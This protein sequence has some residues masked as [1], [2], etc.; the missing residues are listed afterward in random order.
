MSTLPYAYR[1]ATVV[2]ILEKVKE[3]QTPDRFTADFLDTKLGFKGGTSKQFIPFAKKLCLLS[4]DGSPTELYRKFRN[5]AT[6][7][8][9]IAE[10]LRRGYHEIFERNEYA[11]GLDREKFKGLVVEITGLEARN[12][13][14]QMICQTFELLRGMADFEAKEPV[15]EEENVNPLPPEGDHGVREDFGLNLSYTINLVLPKTDDP[16]VLNAI[17]RALRENLLKR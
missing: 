8:L 6:S 16:S 4:G 9:A 15:K 12:R 3:A 14:V 2:R 7:K 17:F 11:Y 5:P 1:P 13:A 10:A